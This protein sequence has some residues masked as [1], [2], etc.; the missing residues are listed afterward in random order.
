ML[1]R[2]ANCARSEV[3]KT[4]CDAVAS[5]VWVDDGRGVMFVGRCMATIEQHS[6]V[7][8]TLGRMAQFLA[9]AVAARTHVASLSLPTSGDKD[10]AAHVAHEFSNLLTSITGYAEM[11]A[12]SLSP[13]SPSFAYLQHIQEAGARAKLVV[14]QALN[15]V[16]HQDREPDVPFDV[17]SSTAEILSDLQMC[18]PGSR[19]ICARL[20]GSPVHICGNPIEL[21]QVLINLCKNAGEAIDEDG[22]ITLSISAIEKHVPQTMTHGQLNPGRY[23]RVCIEDTGHGIAEADVQWIFSPYFTTKPAEKGTGLGLAIVYQIVR[24]LNGVIDV[25]SKL[26]SG[27]CFQLYF[28]AIGESEQGSEQAAGIGFGAT[29]S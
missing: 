17:V 28:P 25:R 6:P 4:P 15:S 13:N 19:S 27:T 14:S 3:S 20:P 26:G 29:A 8:R 5:V 1:F 22:G 16:K 9:F 12:D 2:S 18:M 23:V 7:M 10:A 11:A 21:Q 24:R